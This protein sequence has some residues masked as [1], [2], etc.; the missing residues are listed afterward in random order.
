MIAMDFEN[1]ES[2][3]DTLTEFDQISG[4]MGLEVSLNR[5]AGVEGEVSVGEGEDFTEHEFNALVGLLES[6]PFH[7]VRVDDVL[8]VVDEY[9]NSDTYHEEKSSLPGDLKVSIVPDGPQYYMEAVSESPTDGFFD[10]QIQSVHKVFRVDDETPDWSYGNTKAPQDEVERLYEMA[11]ILP[12]DLKIPEH[13]G[14]SPVAQIE[15][16]LT[17]TQAE[18]LSD[19]Y[20][21]GIDAGT[22]QTITQ[23]ILE[24]P[25]YQ[26]VQENVDAFHS[27]SVTINYRD[28]SPQ[29][30]NE[31]DGLI[32]RWGKRLQ[33]QIYDRQII[34]SRI[35]VS[36]GRKID[37]Q[38][39]R[40]YELKRSNQTR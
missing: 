33:Q 38:V 30:I 34:D 9:R 27:Q 39:S 12:S 15:D 18:V 8:D 2:A 31:D 28:K 20:V 11:Q 23:E 6:G 19:N 16:E 29:Q 10:K 4:E 36:L 1:L 40:R 21:W 25:R 32:E 3:V 22:L 14:E 37:P 17:E 26:Q 35:K 5:L 13:E 24:D 7:Q